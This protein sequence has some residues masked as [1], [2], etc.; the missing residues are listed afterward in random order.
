VHAAAASL[1]GPLGSY[2]AAHAT[3]LA[4]DAPVGTALIGCVASI[5]SAL[6]AYAIGYS[7]GGD[8]L[9]ALERLAGITIR[10]EPA[11]VAPDEIADP[12][13][14]VR[15]RS[16][17]SLRLYVSRGA[18]ARRFSVSVRAAYGQRCAFCGAV[19]GG[20][21]DVRSGVDAA[22]ILAWSAYDLDRVDN[23][24]ALCKLHHWAFDAG[25]ML[26]NYDAGTYSV[27][28][29]P[30]SDRI[31]SESR[32]KLG[33]PEFQIPDEWLPADLGSRPSP[34]VLQRLHQDLAASA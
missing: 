34:A 8:P 9:P 1:P 19:F 27:S 18:S 3:A 12:E 21:D 2:V 16:A 25:L 10:D 20:I 28:M 30:L 29:T 15:V 22:H 32:A 26:P 7:A 6:P 23:G 5:V 11:T 13:F 14:E 24:L 17:A 4:S 33:P 31:D